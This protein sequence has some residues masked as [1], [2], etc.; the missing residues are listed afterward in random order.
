MVPALTP[1][2]G[3]ARFSW[4]V[5]GN[6]EWQPEDSLTLMV[7]GRNRCLR[8]TGAWGRTVDQVCERHTEEAHRGKQGPREIPGSIKSCHE[9]PA[10][11]FPKGCV[12]TG[13]WTRNATG[14]KHGRWGQQACVRTRSTLS[15]FSTRPPWASTPSP[16]KW[17]TGTHTPETVM[18]T[19]LDISACSTGAG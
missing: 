7:Q 9:H 11:P 5:S 4:P 19:Q 17:G 15:Q 12:Y 2:P 13:D 3:I 10:G 14:R 16:T 6:A 1:R 8:R 18:R